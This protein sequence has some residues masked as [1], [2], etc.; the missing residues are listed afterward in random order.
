MLL[1]TNP[2]N[3]RA[4]YSIADAPVITREYAEALA[5]ITHK[6]FTELGFDGIYDKYGL[7]KA[8]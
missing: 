3:D 2:V 4:F 6:E 5:A 7:C 8:P 1:S